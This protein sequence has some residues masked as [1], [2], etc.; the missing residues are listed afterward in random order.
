M[1]HRHEAWLAQAKRDL[2]AGHHSYDAD[3][4]EWCAYQ[5]QQ[6]A[7]K[8]LKA[9]L[10]FNGREVR[11]HTTYQLLDTIQTFLPVAPELFVAAQEPD[12][13]Y[14]RSRYPDSLASGYPAEQYDATIAGECIR[15]AGNILDFVEK[16][17]S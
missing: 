13:H 17:V 10:R 2:Q 1:H 4:Y 3:S 5:A 16:N 9:L 12:Q 11:G 8:A 7:E 6:S 14:F 15:Y